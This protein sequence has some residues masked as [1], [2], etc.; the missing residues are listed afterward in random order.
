[1]KPATL[2]F[3]K[4]I[5]IP[6]LLFA[7]GANA[8]PIGDV[9]TEHAARS[10]QRQLILQEIQVTPGGTIE[11]I[12]RRHICLE[13][14][15]AIDSAALLY[16]REQLE[17]VVVL[18]NVEMYTA[19]GER[20]GAVVL[21]VDAEFDRDFHFESG[22]GQEPL[23]NWYL[24]LISVRRANGHNRGG[25]WRIGYHT[26]SRTDGF[27]LNVI[28]PRLFGD[29]IDL[30]H[31]AE[32]VIHM[33]PVWD[34]D[35]NYYQAIHQ[36][37][38]ELGLRRWSR[39]DVITTLWLGI[40]GFKPAKQL[41]DFEIDDDDN[42]E[43]DITGRLVPIP[44]DGEGHLGLHLDLH[45]DR[46]NPLRPWREG[47]CYDARFTFANPADTDLW[48]G[49]ELDGKMALPLREN[50]AFAV[51]GR[52]AFLR[53]T[54]PHYLRLLLGG[55]QNL[56]GFKPGILTGSRGALGLW[57]INSELRIPLRD[58]AANTPR[59]TG[60]L[61]LDMGD[62]WRADWRHGGF[63]AA[64]GCGLLIRS[65]WVKVINIE[66]ACPLTDT[67]HADEC[68]VMLTLGRSF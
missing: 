6:L 61:F 13:L 55:P 49:A 62:N 33:W 67:E 46:S 56:R 2:R 44:R 24:N 31:E 23:E 29:Y 34:E 54:T 64:A 36:I 58:R 1:M 14:G 47:Y 19:P 68:L 53:G 39:D 26:R 60:T 8:G 32:A 43:I 25:Y 28:H 59:L 48:W 50:W 11:K 12:V 51:R 45:L 22:L 9:P 10:A 40:N 21:H 20:P 3:R 42:D 7:V 27:H 35:R 5:L 15:D 66:V 17:A 4:S 16:A 65:P 37:K 63:S 52:S 57:Q 18:K 38:V 41:E 30:L